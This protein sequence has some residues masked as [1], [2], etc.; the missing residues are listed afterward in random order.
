MKTPL[1]LAFSLWLGC[2]AV[3]VAAAPNHAPAVL[4]IRQ[5]QRSVEGRDLKV[6]RFGDNTD[7][8]I[9][10]FGAFH[11]DEP[12][13]AYIL[14]Q[15]MQ[16]LQQQPAY[17]QDKSIFIVPVV[18]PDGLAR[19]TRVNANKVDL[20]RNF[21]TRDYK[22]GQHRST[23][24]YAGPRA[25]SEPESQLVHELLKPYLSAEY[26]NKIKVLSIHA[27][28]AVN[29]FEGTARPVAERMA[30][31]NGYRAVQDIGYPTPGSFGTYYGKEQGLSVITLETSNES[32]QQA[33]QRHQKALLALLQFPEPNLYP[34]LLPPV[35]DPSP[36]ATPTPEPESEPKSE[37]DSELGPG[38]ER[39]LEP[40]LPR[41]WWPLPQPTPLPTPEP[42]PTPLPSPTLPPVLA[43]VATP[44]PTP[45]AYQ[46][47]T[48][49]LPALSAKAWVKISK[50]DQKLY[51]LEQDKVVASFP[52]AT[53]KG[54]KD[55]PNGTFKLLTRVANPP[56]SG[57]PHLGKRYYPPQHP[58]NP[59]GSRWMQ[60]NAWHYYSGAML[61]IHGTDDP[62][63]IG[64]ALSAGC[65]RMHNQDVELLFEHLRV[66]M[67]VVI[68]DQ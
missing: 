2:L 46:P 14:E 40:A 24:Y 28:L 66:G 63:S 67:K 3:P 45:S 53:G 11:G 56:Y 44:E 65:V 21:P 13:G 29:N 10:L 16:L 30:V 25:L 6:Y 60:F 42:T 31:Y 20:N 55:T 47:G 49:K 34:E 64:K 19:K 1:M 52:V 38:P 43:P 57:S 51:V 15:L 4:Q 62:A 39:E 32:P 68:A 9:F 61:G 12:Q 59:L 26:K 33:W 23:R 22:P 58:N 18:N 8:V 41:R 54:V 27:P 35:L 17:Y 36:L 5:P 48:Q 50:Q 37:P 7:E